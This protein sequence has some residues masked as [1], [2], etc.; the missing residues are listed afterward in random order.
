VN[1]TSGGLSAIS[2]TLAYTRAPRWHITEPRPRDRQTDRICL[3]P[4]HPS[5]VS[6]SCERTDAPPRHLAGEDRE[7]QGRLCSAHPLAR[8]LR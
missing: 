6:L 4:R 3:R 5:R 7:P 1:E 8:S 2:C